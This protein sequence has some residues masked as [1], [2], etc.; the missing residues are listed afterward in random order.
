M[1]KLTIWNIECEDD[2]SCYSIRAKSKKDAIAEYDAKDDDEKR[3]FAR[4]VEKQVYQFS[5]SFELADYL[6]SEDRGYSLM[7]ERRQYKLATAPKKL[8]IFG[9]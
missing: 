9:Y 3:S 8:K 1:P 6:L 5:N 2:S 7:V 4:V